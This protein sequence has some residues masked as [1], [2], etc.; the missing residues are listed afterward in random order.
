MNADSK[1]VRKF[2]G[3]MK[4]LSLGKKVALF[5][6]EWANYEI[7]GSISIFLS[8]VVISQLLSNQ[9]YNL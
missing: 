4:A 5:Y 8:I 7:S 6:A 9:I 1:I 2:F 3:K